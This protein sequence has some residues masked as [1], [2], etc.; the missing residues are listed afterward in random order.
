[1]HMSIFGYGLFPLERNY[2]VAKITSTNRQELRDICSFIDY[3]TNIAIRYPFLFNIPCPEQ[4]SE[5]KS[6]CSCT[7]IV[8]V[9]W[10]CTVLREIYC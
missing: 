2:Y 3:G 9:L 5:P 7:P 4:Y 6:Q 1:M 8:F 10:Q